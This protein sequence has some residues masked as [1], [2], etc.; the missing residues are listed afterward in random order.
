MYRI[1][2]TL[3]HCNADC[4]DALQE[5]VLKAWEKRETLRDHQRFAAWLTR[6]LINECRNVQRKRR[7]MVP[8]DSLPESAAS[9]PD[10][11]LSF[12]LQALP[13]RFRLPLMLQYA[14]GFSH[15]EIAGMLRLPPST[16]RGRIARAKLQ[17]RKELEA[18]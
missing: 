18:Q 13:E 11:D 14:E 6:I 15:Q 10:P 1:A 3:L 16:V 7:R 2:Y 4:E 17:L 5:A 12:A 8:L 9:P